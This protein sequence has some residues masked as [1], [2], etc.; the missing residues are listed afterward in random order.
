[1]EHLLLYGSILVLAAVVSSKLSFRTGIP[2]LI[3]FLGIGMLSGSDGLLGIPFNDPKLT[4][5]IGSL[6]L[7]IILFSGGLETRIESIK[8]VKWQGILLSTIGVILSTLTVGLLLHIFLGFT[9]LK[10]LLIGSIISS[11]DA[12]AVFS[13]LR[14]R[15]TGLKG[16]IR[17]LLELESGSN[18]P[19]A[20]FLTIT[21]VALN[22]NPAEAGI[23]V[24]YLFAKQLIVGTIVGVVM[25]KVMIVLINRLKLEVEGLYPVLSLALMF[26]TY[27]AS[28]FLHGNGFLSVYLAGL[29]LGNHNFIHK[30][31]VISFFDGI[32]WISQISMFIILGLLVFPTRILPVVET[33]MLIAAILIFVARPLSVFASLAFSGFS[34]R[35]KLFISWVGLRGAVPIVF[36]TL[37][38]VFGVENA[39]LIFH[40][41]FFVVLVS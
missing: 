2:V 27:S 31:S 16:N 25:G 12:A 34:F 37:P 19:M 1:M 3:I 30:K 21:L 7:A 13:I 33:G 28:D 29:I 18:D 6:A 10:G 4:Q 5:W 22:L 9:L 24:L 15:K 32:A 17:P 23:S 36:A 35:Q 8:V 14:S 11:T 20:Y 39:D 26:F 40:L 41:V 38:M